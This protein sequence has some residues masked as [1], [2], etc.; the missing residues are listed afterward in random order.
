MREDE[1]FLDDDPDTLT[2]YER[3][4]SI[5]AQEWLRHNEPTSH[6]DLMAEYGLTSSLPAPKAD[7]DLQ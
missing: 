2:L 3:Q 4:T 7:C 1:A 6:E 5:E